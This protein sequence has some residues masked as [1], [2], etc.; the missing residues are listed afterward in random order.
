MVA[1]LQASDYL[2]CLCAV[3]ELYLFFALTTLAVRDLG[4]NPLCVPFGEGG[5]ERKCNVGLR[6][7]H[8]YCNI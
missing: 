2:G 6:C 1:A 4:G 8:S 5:K 7:L 3:L